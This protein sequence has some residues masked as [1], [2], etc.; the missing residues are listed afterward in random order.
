MSDSKLGLEAPA[1]SVTNNGAF[2]GA[3]PNAAPLGEG[4]APAKVI[5]VGE[6][7]VVYGQTA[8]ALPV[9]SLEARARIYASAD[10][11]TRLV[12][13]FPAAE[14]RAPIELDVSSAPD[15]SLLA[16]AVRAGLRHAGRTDRTPWRIELSS[17]IPTGRGLGSSAAV[18]VAIIR[19][20]GSAMVELARAE[21]E[22]WEE[23]AAAWDDETIS[24][25]ALEA[26][27][28]AHGKPSGIDNTVVT[29]ARPIRFREGQ[30]RPLALGQRLRFLVA[31]SGTRGNTAE[32]VAMVRGRA[33]AR[34]R[35]YGDWLA[36]IGRLSDE[37]ARAIAAG[38]VSRLGRLMNLDH[39]IL[40]AMRVS[41]PELDCLV[42]AARNAGAWGAKLTGSGGGGA[43]IALVDEDLE[44]A[45]RT[46]LSEAGA[47]EIFEVL[48]PGRD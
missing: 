23:E 22:D 48:L 44:A 2:V 30:G 34:P 16:T 20:I 45:V 11:G 14:G 10:A 6:H 12:A 40:Q 7:A 24:E 17:D 9:E 37:A 1:L 43:I 32:L 25:L 47:V 26:E 42:S 38:E 35:V 21:G 46:A 39:L 4:R 13:Q 5:L 36:R 33:E 29:F 18:A 8:I 15:E 41:T 28:R 19:A 3:G 27:R 31:D